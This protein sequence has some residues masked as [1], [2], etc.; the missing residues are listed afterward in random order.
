M[1]KKFSIGFLVILT[2]CAAGILPNLDSLSDSEL[3]NLGYQKYGEA[4]AAISSGDIIQ[5]KAAFSQY[6]DICEEAL[7]R[8]SYVV[9]MTAD[10]YQQIQNMISYARGVISGS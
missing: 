2:G 6:L 1:K 5:A 7:S 9:G 4:Q 10:E 3:D 8:P